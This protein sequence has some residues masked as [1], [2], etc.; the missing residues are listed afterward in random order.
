MTPVRSVAVLN[1]PN[2]DRLGAR[3]PALY[4]DMPWPELVALVQEWA[5]ELG[6]SAA[7]S[8][9]AGEGELVQ[10]VH[11]AGRDCAGIV[12]NAGA[13]THTSVALRD[14]VLSVAVPIVEIHLTNPARREAFR[15]VSHLSDVVTG[16]VQ[17]FGAVGYRLA[18]VGLADLLARRK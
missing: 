4:G 1:G 3:Q 17:G 12:L 2:L 16:T 8:Q 14:A 5:R 13:Y 9:A 15:H 6:L 10:L 11:A 18:L 7:V